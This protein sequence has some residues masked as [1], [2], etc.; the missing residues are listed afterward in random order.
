MNAGWTPGAVIVFRNVSTA[1]GSGADALKGMWW[2]R[3]PCRLRHCGVPFDVSPLLSRETKVDDGRV[4]HLLDLLNRSRRDG[5]GARDG[6]FDLGEVRIPAT[7]CL[8]TCALASIATRHP[9]TVNTASVG[10]R[11]CM[12]HLLYAAA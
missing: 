6:R 4:A 10:K 11:H 7:S 1:A 9:M 12:S 3:N 8:T 2:Y 5:A